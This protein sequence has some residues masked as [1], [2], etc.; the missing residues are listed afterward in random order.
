MLKNFLIEILKNIS[1]F[2]YSRIRRKLQKS[3]KINIVFLVSENQK[4]SYEYLY[5]ELKNNPKFNLKILISYP[6]DLKQD[7]K[8]KQ[9][10]LKINYDFYSKADTNIEFIYKDN[11]YESLKKHNP[12]IVFYEQQWGLPLKYKPFFVSFYALTYFSCYGIQM[13]DFKEDYTKNFHYFL[14]KYLVDF[15]ENYNRFLSYNKKFIK[16][17]VVVGYPKLDAYLNLKKSLRK[18]DKPTVI[19][20]PHHSLFSELKTSTFL[21]NGEFILDLA[22]KTKNEVNWVFKPHPRLKYVLRDNNIASDELIEGYYNKWSEIGKIFNEGNY[23]DLFLNSDILIT[24]CCSYLGEYHYT[25][26]PVIRLV[27]SEAVELNELGKNITK[28]YYNVKS[29]QELNKVFY[30]LISMYKENK[31]PKYDITVQKAAENIVKLIQNDISS[32]KI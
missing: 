16:N 1:D 11:K 20:S 32:Y 19:Y 7:E 31:F 23:F 21:K 5:K 3:K 30:D 26:N 22:N 27:N 10:F 12:D 8:S 9:E 2:N 17:C 28:N 24:D 4:W 6:R 13:F 18:N 15:K 25:G 29:N 14:Y